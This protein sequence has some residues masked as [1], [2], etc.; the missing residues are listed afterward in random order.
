MTDTPRCTVHPRF[1]IEAETTHIDGTN[2]YYTDL[3]MR[4][5]ACGTAMRFRG[6]VGLSPNHPAI[7][8][9]G[10]EVTIPAVPDGEELRADNPSALIGYSVSAP[11]GGH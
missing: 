11:P 7:R 2:L 9:D 6:Q 8:I 5:A 4:C 3:R 1:T 10:S